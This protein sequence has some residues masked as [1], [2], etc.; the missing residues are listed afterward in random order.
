MLLLRVLVL[1]LL[2]ITVF[3]GSVVAATVSPIGGEVRVSTGHG[4]LKI[5]APTEFAAGTQVMVSPEGSATIA[6]SNNCIVRVGPAAVTVIQDRS[7]CPTYAKPWHFG[8]EQSGPLPGLDNAF[9][10]TPKVSDGVEKKKKVTEESEQTTTTTEKKK[11]SAGAP[12]M[13]PEPLPPSPPEE[14]SEHHH[15]DHVVLIG[16]VVVGAGALAAILASQGSETPVSP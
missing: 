12:D 8:F 13:N 5:S 14:N 2:S 16:G 15:W 10:F 7:P 3:P 6:Y 11:K 4:F 9:G 1:A